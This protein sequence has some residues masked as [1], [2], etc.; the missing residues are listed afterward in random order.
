MDDGSNFLK[1]ILKYNGINNITE[2][3][4]N[5]NFD[6]L[7][8]YEDK[9]DEF[10]ID[11]IKNKDIIIILIGLSNNDNFNKN[12]F[13]LEKYIFKEYNTR[14][15][16]SY[17]KN[18]KFFLKN[19]NEI[20]E[21]EFDNKKE[22]KI[23]EIYSLILNEL[24][25]IGYY[26]EAMELI[27]PLIKFKCNKNKKDTAN[28]IINYLTNIYYPK[29]ESIVENDILDGRSLSIDLK[30]NYFI[31]EYSWSNPDSN[32]IKEIV[33]FVGDMK[34]LEIAAG[35]GFWSYL[36]KAY[37]LNIIPTGIKDNNFHDKEEYWIKDWIEV[38]NLT[39]EEAFKKY[40]DAE[41]LFLCWGTKGFNIDNFK[42]KYVILVAE[43]D[44]ATFYIRNN[45]K[46]YKLLK[47]IKISHTWG[48]RDF[49]F[50]YKKNI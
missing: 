28:E 26:S 7:I 3:N 49:L 22:K 42:G 30:Y 38:E 23:Y 14:S 8:I 47:K 27:L 36:F 21:P 44:G 41:V 2:Y 37:G 34:I 25:Y 50:I 20:M 33:D 15:I 17:F 45:N 31:N 13:N 16:L 35:I 46:K 43:Y 39:Y 18:I 1:Y 19:N 48:I 40:N 5:I 24:K 11:D 29:L 9:L 10:I 32:I 12:I 6:V 4:N